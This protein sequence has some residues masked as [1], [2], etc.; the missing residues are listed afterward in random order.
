MIQRHGGLRHEQISPY[1][2]FWIGSCYLLGIE[3]DWLWRR[4][5]HHNLERN[6][7]VLSLKEELIVD[8]L[9]FTS[10]KL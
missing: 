6:V 5:E 4:R 8:I 2:R 10:Y 9:S 7:K 1:R 3:Y